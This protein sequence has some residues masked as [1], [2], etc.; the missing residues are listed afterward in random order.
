M[1]LK[2]FVRTLAIGAGAMYFMDPEQGARRR[3]QAR[4]RFTALQHDMEDLWESGTR[5]LQNRVQGL[6]SELQSRVSGENQGNAMG[7]LSQTAAV[8]QMAPGFRLLS[9]G[10]GG[11]LSLY[12]L[13][14]GGISG[15]LVML[16][17]LNFISRG[18][19]NR[20]LV[21]MI[22]PTREGA[23]SIRKDLHLNT[24][25]EE[26]FDFWRNYDNFPRFM[27]HLEEVR[28]LGDD[29]SH[30]VAKGPAGTPV[31]WDAVITQMEP[32][33]VLAWESLP[34]S[35]VYNAGRVRFTSADEGTHISIYMV[36][37]PPGGATGH[38]IA[39]LFGVDPKS[40]MDEDLV[41]LKSLLEQ[42]KTTSEGQE[43]TRDQFS[44]GSGEQ[45]GR[46]RSGSQSG[47]S[48]SGGSGGGGTGGGTQASARQSGASNRESGQPGGGQRRRD[49]VGKTGVYPA[50][51]PLPE[52][53]A[54]VQGMASWGQGERGAAGSEDSGSSE[55][56][57][58]DDL[59]TGK[60][61]KSGKS[62]Q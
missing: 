40:A 41:R 25:V 15:K 3:A 50:S 62:K 16:A 31:E 21:A 6:Q 48:R 17:G 11:L 42:G 51:G 53:D 56:D 13:L 46:T 14:R 30:W 54:D 55:P 12:G 1:G 58:G 52:G 36:Y 10:G 18:L 37:S 61:S 60:G 38:A 9:L 45:G 20:G 19:T 26:V 43:V 24:P 34:G 4:D 29:R 23:I 22:Q 32:N 33:R 39:S 28:D 27:S 5:D 7:L 57:L 2:G 35:E 47:G 44:G 8:Q 49:E 59:S